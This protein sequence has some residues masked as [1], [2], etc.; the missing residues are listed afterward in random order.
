MLD[1]SIRIVPESSAAVSVVSVLV[2]VEVSSDEESLSLP[3]ADNK[4]ALADK[5][6]TKAIRFFFT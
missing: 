2:E 5:M 6:P 1:P 4:I 3:Q